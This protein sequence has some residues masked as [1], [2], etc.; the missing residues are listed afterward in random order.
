MLFHLSLYRR[1][2]SKTKQGHSPDDITRLAPR[3]LILINMN[4]NL[5]RAWM[6]YNFYK[7]MHLIGMF[8]IFMA[9]GAL[10]LNAMS[11]KGKEGLVSRK[12][13]MASHGVGLLLILVGGFGLLA[14][15]KVGWPDWIMAKLIIWLFLGGLLALVLR[16][17][18]MA[19]S[20]W[21]GILGLGATAAYLAVFKPF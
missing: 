10:L 7:V 19:K 21:F 4:L 2:R 6:S 3:S 20:L 12:L 13:V 14:R 16:K 9:Y 5:R 15:T 11:G 18:Q 1:T 17:P 8:T